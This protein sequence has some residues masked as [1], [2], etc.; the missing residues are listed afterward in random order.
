MDKNEDRKDGDDRP[1][2]EPPTAVRLTDLSAGAGFSVPCTDSGS[3]AAA[4]E[5][6][7]GADGA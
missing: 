1:T 3:S 5:D 7:T 4:C 2:Y 6:G